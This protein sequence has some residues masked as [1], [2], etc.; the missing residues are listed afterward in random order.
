[1]NKNHIKIM[2]FAGAVLAS[3]IGI[4]AQTSYAL[5]SL[6]HWVPPPKD[7]PPQDPN[8]YGAGAPDGTVHT[9]T[10]ANPTQGTDATTPTKPEGKKPSDAD[11]VV[12]VDSGKSRGEGT[13]TILNKP[14][15]CFPKPEEN[16]SKVTL[17]GAPTDT[18][19]ITTVV[20]NPDN[21]KKA[22]PVVVPP[23]DGA[24]GTGV[25]VITGEYGATQPSKPGTILIVPTAPN[26]GIVFATQQFQAQREKALSARYTSLEKLQSTPADQRSAVVNEMRAAQLQ[27]ATEQRE[28]ARQLRNDLRT[29]REER[30]AAAGN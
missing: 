12:P 17:V 25:V 9:M 4:G 19:G 24:A 28:L 29:L 27:Q 11:P 15:D 21:G 6:E 23:S 26:S 20:I 2:A 10:E 18:V 16:I 14:T 13:V 3:F 30:K 8:I 7:A 1:M 22:P 5:V